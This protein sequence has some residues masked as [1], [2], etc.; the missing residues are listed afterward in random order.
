MTTIGSLISAYQTDP[1]SAVHKL[2]F[3]TRENYRNMCARIDRDCGAVEISAVNARQVLRWYEGWAADGRAAMGHGLVGMLRTLCTFGATLLEDEDCR[4]LKMILHDM[5]FTMPRPRQERMTA[6]QAS[7]IRAMAHEAGFHSVALAQAV[8]FECILRQ[9]DVIGE[10]IPVTEPGASQIVVGE[11]KWL[12]GIQWSEIDENLVLRHV[13]SK[14][15][16]EIEINLRLAPMVVEELCLSQLDRSDFPVSGPLIVSEKTG[17]PYT[18]YNFRR[19]WRSIA[20]QA[21][22]PDAV[23][24]MDSRAGA[25]SEATDAGASLE[26][27]RHAATHSNTSTTANYSRGSAGKVIEVQKARNAHRERAA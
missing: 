9:K 1:D 26:Q 5:R 14:R 22:V 7:A 21:G 4:R 20:R 19:A 3:I 25:I 11:L 8:Q 16:K 15:S 18:D 12:R 10:W 23:F 2:R 6:D 24:N 17:L 13:T 27:V